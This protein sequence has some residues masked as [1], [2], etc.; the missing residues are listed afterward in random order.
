MRTLRREWKNK[1]SGWSRR[2][3]WYDNGEKSFRLDIEDEHGQANIW[4]TNAD[5][6][7]QAWEMFKNLADTTPPLNPGDK[8]IVRQVMAVWKK[9]DNE[10]GDGQ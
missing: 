6:M 5:D 9:A 2:G 8:S 1:P 10:E 7:R 4:L 3:R